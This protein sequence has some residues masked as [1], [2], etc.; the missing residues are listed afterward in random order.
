MMHERVYVKEADEEAEAVP[1]EA[2]AESALRGA[3]AVGR[4]VECQIKWREFFRFVGVDSTDCGP[5]DPA[6]A[7]GDL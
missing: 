1:A 5:M 6:R 2:G 4:G 7:G 3:A